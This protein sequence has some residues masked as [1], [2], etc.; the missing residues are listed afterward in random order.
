MLN[1]L[2]GREWVSGSAAVLCQLCAFQRTGNEPHGV[3]LGLQKGCAVAPL[4][5]E[6]RALGCSEK[7]SIVRQHK[8]SETD[9]YGAGWDGQ[10]VSDL[11]SI[12]QAPELLNLRPPWEMMSVCTSYLC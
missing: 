7:S 8:K 11:F 12:F 4:Q 1:A 10:L 2:T 9:R 3:S 5:R 6:E